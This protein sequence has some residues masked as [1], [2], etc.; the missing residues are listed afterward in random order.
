[1]SIK[2]DILELL[3]ANIGDEVLFILDQNGI[4]NIR[5]FEGQVILGEG[6]KNISSARIGKQYN[7]GS[8]VITSDVRHAINADIG[9]RI[10]ILDKNGNVMIR[11]NVILGE[12]STNIFNKDMS[13][14]IIELT[15]S[16]LKSNYL[17]VPKEIIDIL[18]SYSRGKVIFSLDEYGNIIVSND[19]G[20]N[21]LL[22]EST[23]FFRGHRFAV[24]LIEST[25]DILG[26]TTK[27]LW[28]FDEEGNVIIKNNL[29][30]DSC[31]N[32]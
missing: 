21:L 18:G 8:V 12:C 23:L 13:M 30:P 2:P 17:S 4:V 28:F 3:G 24:H 32:S 31:V 14:L 26:N 5:K 19:I 20:E 22:Q 16:S 6:E 25:Q 15:S 10:L 1:M 11:N 29:L 9:D 27:I 7:G